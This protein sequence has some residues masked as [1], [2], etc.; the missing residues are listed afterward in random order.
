MWIVLL[1]CIALCLAIGFFV[2]FPLVTT[3]EGNLNFNAGTRGFADENELRQT[4][5]LRDAL[6]AKLIKGSSGQSA[7]DDLSE[8]DAL[9]AL[10]SVCERLR[11]HDFP[12]FPALL[13]AFAV[14][15][16]NTVFLPTRA[17]AQSETQAQAQAPGQA[18]AAP[19]LRIPSLYVEPSTQV[20]FPSLHQF[21][22]S[23]RMGSMTVF[24]LGVFQ[25]SQGANVVEVGLPFPQ[26]FTE[27]KLSQSDAVV[28]AK[29]TQYPVVQLPAKP[30]ITE[31]R[32]EFVLPATFGTLVWQNPA[33]PALPGTMLLLMPEYQSALR[34]LTA[35][36]APSLNL[37]PAR[38]TMEPA[39]FRSERV[40]E[41]YDPKDPNYALL[42]R[43]PPEYTRNLIRT[44]VNP[45]PYPVFEVAGVV[46]S[47]TPLY[48]LG[49]LFAAF[50]F[51]TA[52]FTIS[53][54]AR[55]KK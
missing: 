8:P 36:F 44:S 54:T 2:L 1:L 32:A 52:G 5:G 29:G 4:L 21:V 25:A 34:N 48:V 39:G 13:L 35:S 28:L 49:G 22:L 43:M 15:C 11:K 42:S 31:V 17:H 18:Q 23:P 50:L 9:D 55:S 30:G 16:S 38:I 3:A 40:Q 51:G 14:L 7:V 12:I 20:G 37:W 6:Y 41:E 45:E 33:V 47:R 46:P 19:E 26:G 53:R 24:Y 10:L 27:L